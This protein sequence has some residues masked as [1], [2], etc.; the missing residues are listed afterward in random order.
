MKYLLKVSAVNAIFYVCYKL[1][2]QRDTFFEAY[3]WFLMLGL[4]TS[5]VLPFIV[6][7]IYIEYTPVAVP[8]FPINEITPS[9]PTEKLFNPL[10]Y[11]HIIYGLG[12][13]FFTIRFL[14]QLT[15]LTKL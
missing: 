12:G 14:V 1:L 4:L 9:A 13:A 6:I 2:L 10:D 3:R 11:L 7:P 8:G 5:F 15:S